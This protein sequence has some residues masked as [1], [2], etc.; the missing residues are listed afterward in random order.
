[1][2]EHIIHFHCGV[3][4]ASTEHFR[5]RC[6]EALGKGATGL[7]LN[8]STAGGSTAL[9]FTLYNFLKSLKVPIRALNSGNIESMGIVIY[10][11]AQERIVCPHSRF[12]IHPMSWYFNQ[13]SVDHSRMREYLRSLDNDLQRYV[14]IYESETVSAVHPLDIGRCLSAEE[15]VIRAEDSLACGIAHRVEQLQFAEDAVHWT[16]SAS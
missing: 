16:V 13:S 14:N 11:A 2:S 1:M 4:Q 7:L 5:D 8:L 9:G 10:L 3:D 15:K 12:L 6:L